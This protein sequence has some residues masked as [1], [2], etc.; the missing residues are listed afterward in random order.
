MQ[1]KTTYHLF[2]CFRLAAALLLFGLISGCKD[3]QHRGFEPGIA[4]ARPAWQLDLFLNTDSLIAE[5]DQLPDAESRLDSLLFWADLLKNYNQ[6]AALEYANE[7]Y[8]MATERGWRLSQA[9]SLYYRAM[10]KEKKQRFGERIEDAI[11]D[12]KM[13]ARLLKKTGRVDWEI[14]TD[15]LLGGLYY[16]KTEYDT[17]L[18]YLFQALEMAEHANATEFN[19]LQYKGEILHDLGNVYSERDSTIEEALKNYKKSLDIYLKTNNQA[20][21]ARLRIG[22]GR[23]YTQQGQYGQAEREIR[24]SEAYSLDAEDYNSLIEVYRRLGYLRYRQYLISEEEPQFMEAMQFFRTCLSYQQEN[25]YDTHFLMGRACYSRTR[26]K[27]YNWAY[28]DSAIIYYKLA[29]E[30]AREEGAIGMMKEMVNRITTLCNWRFSQFGKDCSD[31]LDNSYSAFLNTNYAAIVDTITIGLQSANQRIQEFERKEQAAANERRV[32]NNWLI[33]GVGLVIA[34]L[35]FLLILQWQK[36]KRLKVRMEALRA[37]I[38]PHFISNSLNAIENLVNQDQREAAAKYLIHFSRLSRQILN[39][40]R[41]PTASL[42]EEIKM[43]EH[44][45]ALEQ[46]RFRDKLH[47]NIQISPGLNPELIEMPAMILQPYAENAIWHGIKPKPGPGLLKIF[48]ERSG[49]YLVCIIED[50]GVGREKARE[51]Q[52]G[53]VLHKHKSQGM[54]ITEERLKALGKI[55]GSR[56]EVIDLHDTAGQAVGT[57]VVVRLPFKLLKHKE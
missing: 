42:A 44:F 6:N 52:A 15:N 38:N 46:L 51:M 25:L 13:S 45:L 11:V 53:S 5:L 43:L 16:K 29:M 12:A 30:E 55:K 50:D 24:L 48:I 56:V 31:L 28:A 33:S 9:I 3:Y 54:A 49:K 47:Y 36:Q 21:A 7:A 19:P 34:G 22:L 57:R 40:S 8:R 35:I 10:I 37:Q 41:A 17:A 18:V 2:C 1:Q 27:P 4:A 39:S 23:L 14:R 20:A 32:R 26:K